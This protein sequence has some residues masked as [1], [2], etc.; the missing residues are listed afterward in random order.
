MKSIDYEIAQD[1]L[2]RL[3][4]INPENYQ[5]LSVT[6][7][8]LSRI[9]GLVLKKLGDFKKV[10]EDAENRLN[11]YEFGKYHDEILKSILIILKS[12]DLKIHELFDVWSK[13]HKH[14]MQLINDLDS[15]LR[16]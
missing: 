12:Y 9:R 4:T 14:E 2:N 10:I 16:D 3:F 7:E 1:I 8:D 15:I 6:P 5:E 11:E 13:Y